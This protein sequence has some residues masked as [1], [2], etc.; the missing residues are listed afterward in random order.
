[1]SLVRDLHELASFVGEPLRW[2]NKLRVPAAP[3]GVAGG[4]I[5]PLLGRDLGLMASV[6]LPA[7]APLTVRWGHYRPAPLPLGPLPAGA[8]GRFWADLSQ[9]PGGIRHHDTL[10][11]RLTWGIPNGVQMSQWMGPGIAS[12]TAQ[13][14]TL[15]LYLM[16]PNE[17][18]LEAV[19]QVGLGDVSAGDLSTKCVNST[20][21]GL[22]FGDALWHQL[23]GSNYA[24]RGGYVTKSGVAE[25]V[26]V[27]FSEFEPTGN[28]GYLLNGQPGTSSV[29]IPTDWCGPI[30]GFCD[31]AGEWTVTEHW[32]SPPVFEAWAESL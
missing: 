9:F 24:R 27:A 18:E 4:G 8:G 16:H 22:S 21:T 15:R 32:V 25:N 2:G 26:W 5:N 19:A 29:A 13:Q 28:E 30:W 10:R 12:I 1:M 6:K 20:T 7:P 23:V 17:F 11:M 31:G 3:T 14:L